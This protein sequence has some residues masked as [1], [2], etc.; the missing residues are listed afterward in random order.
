MEEEIEKEQTTAFIYVQHEKEE[1]ADRIKNLQ[2]NIT[3]LEDGMNHLPE[4]IKNLN[5]VSYM[6]FYWGKSYSITFNDPSVWKALKMAGVI[7][8]KRVFN[9]SREDNWTWESGTIKTPDG[10]DYDV[11]ISKADKPESCR[12]E[13]VE[14]TIKVKRLVAICPETDQEL[15]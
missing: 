12:L 4:D 8:L 15:K 11:R 6:H 10:Y 9:G 13:E 7:G 1:L 14:E 5:G 3:A 2:D